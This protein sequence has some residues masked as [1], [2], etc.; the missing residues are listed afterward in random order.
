MWL[1]PEQV[2]SDEHTFQRVDRP[3]SL[4]LPGARFTVPELVA[5]ADRRSRVLHKQNVF[6][7]LATTFT[8]MIAH[9]PTGAHAAVGPR[10]GW[11]DE[12]DDGRYENS[13]EHSNRQTPARDRIDEHL[14]IT[15]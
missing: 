10:V 3:G 11:C 7:V 15:S 12:L 9:G 5:A 4:V 1:Y 13:G 6:S 2:V 14:G 8:L